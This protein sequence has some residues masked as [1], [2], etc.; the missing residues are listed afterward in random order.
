[1]EQART[2]LEQVLALRRMSVEDFRAAYDRM[3][4]DALSERQAYRWLAGEIKTSPYPRAQRALESL[5]GEPARSLLGAP[6]QHKTPTR[7]A[8]AHDSRRVIVES[9]ERARSFLSVAELTNVGPETL[10]QLASEIRRLSIEYPQQP[11][12]S[13]IGGIVEAQEQAFRLLDGRQRPGQTVDLFLL[14][15]VSSGLMARASHDLG[16]P[17]AAM[18]HARA[19]SVCAKNAGHDG[20]LAWARGLQSLIAYWS[21]SLDES[22][23]YADQFTAADGRHNGS[24]VVWLSASRA[25]S[26]AALGR[27]VEAETAIDIA[28]AAR[29]LV[30]HDELDD[31]GGLCTFSRPRQLYYAADALAWCGPD[32]AEQAELLALEALDAYEQAP[33]TVRAFGDE[34]GVRCAL[35]TARISRGEI[36][37]ANEAMEAVLALPPSQRIHGI[38]TS[39]QNVRLSLGRG[40][41]QGRESVELD[42]A[43]RLF[44]DDKLALPQQ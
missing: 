5:F 40:A 6:D 10:E 36:D 21:G 29:D 38:T 12:E 41:N 39:V 22:V 37:G 3:S 16:A 43:M 31:L 34:A 18:T 19:A 25:R 42:E 28:S 26:L 14:A 30:Q 35:A 7:S 44:C 11:L 13:L 17:H 8:S 32:R 33:A 9:A 24:A 20:L 23:R 15:G 4:G 27:G 2:R 1:M